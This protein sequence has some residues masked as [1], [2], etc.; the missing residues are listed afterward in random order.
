MTQVL[1]SEANVRVLRE[2]CRHGGELAPASLVTR[3]QL[4]QSSVREALLALA[5]TG[6]VERLGAGR[7]QLFRLRRAHPLASGIDQ[8]F[9]AEEVRF[10]SILGAV[11]AAASSCG[12]HVVAVWLYGSVARGEDRMDSDLDVAV[13]TENGSQEAVER[14]MRD[15]LDESSDSLAFRASVVAIDIGTMM[16]LMREK[17]GWWRSA[18][19]DSIPLFGERP[20]A[21]EQWL[22]RRERRAQGF[23]R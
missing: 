18:T 12:P 8:L 9:E 15:A 20:D 10:D 6:I 16:R 14:R 19:R 7:N 23:A 2:L 5:Q 22:R 1:G 21:L 3:T 11:R 4:A 17:D 13:V